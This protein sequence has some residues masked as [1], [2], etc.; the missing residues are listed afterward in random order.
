MNDKGEEL[1]GAYSIVGLDFEGFRSAA[2]RGAVV[3]MCGGE[4]RRKVLLA[5]LRARMASV[6]ITTK[7][8]ADW[9]L[10][11][12]ADGRSREVIPVRR[13]TGAGQSIES[14]PLA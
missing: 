1:K 10:T 3:L 6:V 4:K 11:Q 8:T 14:H 13:Q 12:A 2:E 5:A 9:I 7:A